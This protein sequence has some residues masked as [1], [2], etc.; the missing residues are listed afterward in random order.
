MK[1]INICVI[2]VLILLGHSYS[3]YSQNLVP[4]GSFEQKKGRRTTARPWRFVNTVD[5]FV[6]NGRVPPET[7][8]WNPP[9]A[10]N[11]IAYVGLRIYPDYREFI[12]IKLT[13]K[14]V[15]AQKYYFEMWISWSTHS[16]NFA[17]KFGASL[18]RKK[19]SYTSDYYITTNPPQ[20]ELTDFKGIVQSDSSQWMK[21]SGVYRAKGAERYL[22][23]GN[24]SN[25]SF[26]DRLKRKNWYSLNFWHHE[27]YYYVDAVSLVRLQ[28]YSAEK[29]S[30]L[31]VTAPVPPESYANENYVYSL[32]TDS[33]LVMKNI[34]FASGEDK[35]LPRSYKDLELIM[36]Y[37]NENPT[38]NIQVIGHTDNIG[39]PSSNQKLS[40]KRA[41]SVYDYFLSNYI[42]KDRVSYLGNGES[43]PMTTNET[44]RGRRLNRRVEIQLIN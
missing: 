43:S 32:E 19:P 41:K 34:Q 37:L 28:E 29:D 16:N 1:S 27:A 15:E 31:A 13:Q 22:T 33:S 17:K 2:I 18:Y 23:I 38:K 20:I 25:S 39:N 44:P 14:L 6:E 30:I 11:G 36:E 35:L 21:I 7:E 24:F 12:Q 8:D 40:E 9:K 10:K 26:K 4:N 42:K 3:S 5:Y